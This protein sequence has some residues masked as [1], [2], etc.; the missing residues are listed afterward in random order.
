MMEKM[1]LTAETG[2]TAAPGDGVPFERTSQAF[3]DD[4]EDGRTK[5]FFL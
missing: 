5:T 3:R 1:L 2:E 4:G